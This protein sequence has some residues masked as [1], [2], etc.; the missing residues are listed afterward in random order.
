MCPILSPGVI[1]H[2]PAVIQPVLG[3]LTPAVGELV[4]FFATLFAF[5]LGQDELRKTLIFVFA[6]QDDRLRILR[7]LN[8]IKRN[9]TPY[10]GTESVITPGL[11]VA[12]SPPALVLGFQHP[13]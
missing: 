4:V 6:Q 5:L 7:I 1:L 13:P 3:F 11:S 12:T 9:L 10:F 2:L 8:D